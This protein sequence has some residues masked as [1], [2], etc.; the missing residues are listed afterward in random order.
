MTLAQETTN[1][2]ENSSSRLQLKQKISIFWN[3]LKCCQISWTQNFHRLWPWDYASILILHNT[4]ECKPFNSV[5]MFFSFC[6]VTVEISGKN[7]LCWPFSLF[8]VGVGRSFFYYYLFII[9]FC[10]YLQCNI[11]AITIQVRYLLKN[12]DNSLFFSPKLIS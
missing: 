9:F 7:S 4:Q 6:I 12:E 10:F 2:I 8:F 1:I 5:V 3:L 11:T